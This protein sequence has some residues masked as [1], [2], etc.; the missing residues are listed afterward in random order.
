VLS[1]T[2]LSGTVDVPT[3]LVPENSPYSIGDNSVFRVGSGG[4]LTV[5]GGVTIKFGKNAVLDTALGHLVVAGD[6]ENPAIFQGKGLDGKFSDATGTI[7]LGLSEIS[8]A[9]FVGLL[10][11]EGGSADGSTFESVVFE[12]CVNALNNIAAVAISDS[13]FSANKNGIKGIHDSKIARV[14]FDSNEVG[15]EGGGGLVVAFSR[16]SSNQVGFR[17]SDSESLIVTNC[18]FQQNQLA[19]DFTGQA[20]GGVSLQVTYSDLNDNQKVAVGTFQGSMA[21]NYWGV[22]TL[23]EIG[24]LLNL[25]ARSTPLKKLVTPFFQSP[26]NGE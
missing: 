4:E 18:S 19:F 3:T 14:G 12:S 6:N 17:S 5:L 22:A 10:T 9:T 8:H 23:S 2:G 15:F 13:A 21:E 26:I 7:R 20:I 16:F 24:E 1:D 11:V 25:D